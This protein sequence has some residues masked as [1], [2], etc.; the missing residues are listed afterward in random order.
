MSKMKHSSKVQGFLFSEGEK[1][2]KAFVGTT[3]CQRWN[4]VLQSRV[5]LISEGKKDQKA[6]VGTL[7]CHRWPLLVKSKV[8]L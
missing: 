2:Q 7:K 5:F 4:I 1:D 3:K 6:L 8:S